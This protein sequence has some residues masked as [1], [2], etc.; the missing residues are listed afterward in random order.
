MLSHLI[1]RVARRVPWTVRV[2]SLLPPR[3]PAPRQ[4]VFLVGCPRSGTTM[5]FEALKRHPDLGS[6]ES[7]GHVIWERFHHPRERGWESNAV[8]RADIAGGERAYAYRFVELAAPG[9]RF[10]DKTPRNCLRIP[11]LDTLFPD[12]FFVFLR[13]RAADN[14]NS[15]LEGWKAHPRW[16]AYELPEPLEGLGWRSGRDW[17][18]VLVPGWRELRQAPLEEVCARQWIACNEAVLA[19]RDEIA[20]ERWVDVS[21]ED[22]VERPEEELERVQRAL[23]LAVAPAV[24]EFAAELPRTPI[25][26][27]TPPRREKWRD[28]NREAIERI[29]PLVEPTERRLGYAP[30]R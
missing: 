24:V 30:A 27:V 8:G 17:S 29:L 9:R 4:P 25:N 21:Y 3:A 22:V 23:G 2:A 15:L 12:A 7:E 20:P 28:Q 1:L 13:R 18:F 14:V 10:L 11:Y 16:I 5:L 6:I 19:A 26:V